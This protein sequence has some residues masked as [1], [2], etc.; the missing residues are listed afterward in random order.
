MEMLG[1]DELKIIPAVG[2]EIIPPGAD[3]RG[4]VLALSAQKASEVASRVGSE[5]AVVIGADT[6]VELDGKI[7]G[8]PADEDEAFR[9]L[10]ALSGREHNVYTG[11][12]LVRG[13]ERIS[14]AEHTRVRFRPLSDREI[15]AYIKTGEPM[16]KAG[17]YGAQG[18]GSLFVEALDGD[19]FNVMGLPLC[20]LGKMLEKM[21]VEL[22]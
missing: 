12:T 20:R 13:A 4:T 14:E 3:A 18:L 17:A 9:M 15:T 1:V 21:G 10:R 6:V 22:L 2:D 11:V 19:F 16:D 7:L 5:N 8:K